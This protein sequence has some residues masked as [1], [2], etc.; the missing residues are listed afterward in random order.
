V[1]L[2]YGAF[3]M[4]DAPERLIASLLDDLSRDR[5]EID[6]VKFSVPAFATSTTVS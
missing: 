5:V 2:I 6:M 4:R 3:F 1:N